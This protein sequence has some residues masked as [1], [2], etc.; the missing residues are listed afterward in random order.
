MAE[1]R[2]RLR[3]DLADPLAGDAELPAH[4]LE[5]PGVAIDQPEPQLDDLLLALRQRVEHRL[6]LLL[7]EDE[8][9]RVDRDHGLGVFDEVAEVGVLLLTDRRLQGH[10]LL[11]DLQDLPNLLRGDAHLPPDLLR[12]RLPAEV[13]EQ[14][15]LDP[16]QLV[17]RL[18]HVHG[19]PDRPG[20]IGDGPG[21]GLP[22][23]PRGVR[24]ELEALR[25]VEL[26]HGADQAEVP[27]LDQVE[28]EHPPADVPF[29]DRHDEAEVRLDQLLLGQ[30][31]IPLDLAKEV[32]GLLARSGS[33]RLRRGLPPDPLDLAELLQLMPADLRHELDHLG[34][35]LAVHTAV[36]LD[37]AEEVGGHLA[38]LDP[39]GEVDLL[40]RGQGGDL[41]DLLEVHADGIVGGRLEAVLLPGGC[42]RRVLEVFAGNLD[43]LD[44]LLPQ[45][46]LD[47]AQEVLD[48][49]GADVLDREAL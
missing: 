39:H 35:L 5:G 24:R 18:H 8:R 48:L 32:V 14:L 34:Q 31:A 22:N 10:R 44:A 6:E 33:P 43:H 9:G 7:E 4:L 26:L 29:G 25:V 30:L 47:L 40:R 45:V 2:E 15:A 23:P 13:L 11:R 19:D 42:R 20:L 46:L 28:E 38:R 12:E 16:D 37:V 17:D 1:L 21:D 27:L 3:L 36:V 41:A 49:L